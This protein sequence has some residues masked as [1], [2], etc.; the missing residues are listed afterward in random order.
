MADDTQWI[1]VAY[2]CEHPSLL[3]DY[4]PQVGFW[5]GDGACLGKGGR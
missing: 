3:A 5:V 4:Y 1:R 2:L